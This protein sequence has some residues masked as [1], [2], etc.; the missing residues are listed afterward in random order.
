MPDAK[1]FP[2]RF[3]LVR[4]LIKLSEATDTFIP[5]LPFITN[6]LDHVDYKKKGK[7]KVEESKK[8]DMNCLLRVTKA[9]VLEK[10]FKDKTINNVYELFLEYLS[11]QSHRIGFPELAFIPLLKVKKFLKTNCKN[12]EHS[13][14]LKQAQEKVEENIKYIES[15][16]KSVPFKF[17]DIQAI[18][19]WERQRRDEVPPISKFYEQWKKMRN[20]REVL[21]RDLV[22]EDDDKKGKKRDKKGIQDKKGDKKGDKSRVGDDKKKR[23]REEDEDGDGP[24]KDGDE[25]EDEV[26]GAKMGKGKKKKQKKE[27]KRKVMRQQ[28]EA[29]PEIEFEK[30]LDLS[31]DDE[32]GSD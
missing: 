19:A 28:L 8:M 1:F 27:K 14:L 32:A 26:K 18:D 15:K 22:E 31:S 7:A 10:Q 25:G 21:E 5:V 23:K 29:E 6:V 4:G 12:P 24:E 11:T 9:Q 3:H 2:V 17:N 13:R 30:G 20:E 16:R